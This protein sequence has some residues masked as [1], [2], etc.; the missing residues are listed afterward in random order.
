MLVWVRDNRTYG[1][2]YPGFRIPEPG[3]Q[4]SEAVVEW[5]NVEPRIHQWDG[6]E[7]L[8]TVFMYD[9]QEDP[10]IADQKIGEPG[11]YVVDM[12]GQL[13]IIPKAEMGSIYTVLG[14]AA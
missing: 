3:D 2:R 5:L 7:A 1:V 14:E 13:V 9:D 8:F 6:D 10:V 11:D 4:P 12:R